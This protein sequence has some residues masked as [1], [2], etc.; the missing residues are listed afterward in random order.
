MR[1]A[2]RETAGAL[3]RYPQDANRLARR[4]AELHRVDPDCVLLSGGG[5]TELLERALHAVGCAGDELVSPF[6]TF[7]VLSALASRTG[8]RHRMVPAPQLRDGLFAPHRARELLAACGP[9]TRAVYVA[10]PDNPTG[11][12][13]PRDQ[14][15]A[16]RLGLGPRVA[17]LLDEAWSLE[18]PGDAE[19]EEGP[20][21]MPAAA[22]QGAPHAAPA[23]APS[24]APLLRLR[25]LSKLYGLAGL[26][27]GYALASPELASLL[28][29][30]ELPFPVG[31]PQLAAALATLDELPR[32]RRIALLLQRK[33][34]R[35]A[36]GIRALG[37]LASEGASPLVLVRDPRPGK[38]AGPLLF[39]LRAAGIAAQEAHWDPAALTL[40]V[41]S[42]SQHRR[43]LAALARAVGDAP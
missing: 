13:L 31:A 33:R 17:L 14:L 3:Q 29:R 22:P 11:A 34:E 15:S 2:L 7:E 26:R 24:A 38:N 9:R 20:L 8:L 27:V 40:S 18:L 6:P 30:L 25:S 37:L 21:A 12:S 35:L 1:R 19:P 32:A 43:A 42:P 4:L 10:S 41:G 23:S 39:A 36:Q 5:A 28:R 16:L